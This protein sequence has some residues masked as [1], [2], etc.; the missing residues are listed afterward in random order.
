MDFDFL[1]R[2]FFLVL[3]GIPLTLFM[4]FFTLI[5]SLPFAILVAVVRKREVPFLCKVLGIYVSFIRGTPI[6]V[7]IFI[8][9]NAM[10]SL[11]NLLFLSLH[12]PVKV[13]DVN[14]LLYALIVFTLNMIATMSEVFRSS[15]LS[16][17]EGQYEAALCSGLTTFQTYRRI[18]LPQ[19]FVSA[20]PNLCSLAVEMIKMTSLAFAMTVQ[21]VMA[22]A[23]IE[24][25]SG[26][27][28]IEA[29]LDVFV[30]YLVLCILTE[31]V[32]RLM[33]KKLSRYKTLSA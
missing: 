24:A 1:I 19:A 32:F 18:I 26:Y 27:N 6:I 21:D 31:K 33:E 9:Y 4:T 22:I 28:F 3:R 7:Q 16:I 20:L 2:T 8:V 10:P 11:L 14:P 25:S 12:I 23:K 17:D 29:Y 30:V 13:F 5:F 15:L